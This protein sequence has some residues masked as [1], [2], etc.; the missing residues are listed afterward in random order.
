MHI[1]AQKARFGN[2][3]LRILIG[4]NSFGSF[5]LWTGCSDSG[6]AVPDDGDWCGVK[7]GAP[8]AAALCRTLDGIAFLGGLKRGLRDELEN[9]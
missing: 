7:Y 2:T 5:S 6:R 3:A 9:G 4:S 8:G 1:G